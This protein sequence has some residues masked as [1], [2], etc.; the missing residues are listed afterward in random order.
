MR[1]LGP[2]H[3]VEDNRDCGGYGVTFSELN[4]RKK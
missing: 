1:R 4:R 2:W 3:V